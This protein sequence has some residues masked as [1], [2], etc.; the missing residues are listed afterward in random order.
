[1]GFFGGKKTIPQTEADD[2]GRRV[3]RRSVVPPS[4]NVPT[5]PTKAASESRRK[6]G[7]KTTEISI[8]STTSPKD[9]P[10]SSD[11]IDT[12]AN[13]TK[14]GSSAQRAAILPMGERPTRG[15]I[16]PGTSSLPAF[17]GSISGAN[18]SA[19][20][21]LCRTG[22]AALLEFLINKARLITASQAEEITAKAIKD[23]AP[24]DIVAVNLSFLTE[25][26]LVNALTQECFLAHLKVNQYEIRKKALDTISREDSTFYGVF[27]VDKLGGL[28]TLAMIN[29]L[30]LETLRILETKTGL[31]IKKVVATRSEITQGI[32]K[33][34]SGKVQAKDNSI[35]FTQ[36]IEPKSVT[37]M[38][39]RI[40][41]TTAPPPPPSRPMPAI[42]PAL[43]SIVPEIQ[44]IDELLA[45]EEVIRPAIIE[46]VSI[47]ADFDTTDSNEFIEPT[48]TASFKAIR[49]PAA[50]NTPHTGTSKNKTPSLAD[51]PF[52]D[53][54]PAGTETVGPLT[55]KVTQAPQTQIPH[56]APAEIVAQPELVA[57]PEIAAPKVSPEPTPF[58]TPTLS[59]VTTSQP[60][61][62]K[63]APAHIVPPLT[64]VS[65]SPFI[66][67]APVATPA[68]ARALPPVAKPAKPANA[69]D[70]LSTASADSNRLN[71][72][73]AA[74][75]RFSAA[76]RTDRASGTVNLIPV[77]EDEFQHA[78]THGKSRV[79]DKW[80]G[81]QTRN[82]I[83][84]A[85]PVEPEL[86][87]LLAGL[88]ASGKSA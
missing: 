29:P 48:I 76:P 43:E 28:L 32:D 9:Q 10:S 50:S 80:V 61:V 27:P 77:M 16:T 23:D 57:P 26:Q 64:P 68:P 74:T 87:E 39:A 82:R 52:G 13:P 41:P 59:P 5:A 69:N 18:P 46:P 24:I 47:K 55:A 51:F 21:G 78:I 75:T 71:T 53:A 22:D 17:S 11:F 62:A 56:L 14:S 81:L 36:D 37:S 7:P 84:N 1:M 54:E 31:D 85:V 44:D 12:V 86:N 58:F 25:D 60:P 79:F 6:I 19:K 65:S 20:G 40:S 88:Y 49:T 30:D 3:T 72:P 63:A 8:S 45:G 2:A 83:I 33:Y 70:V 42:T 34:Y 66:T 35:S 38:M 4:A 73:R 67:P 15:P